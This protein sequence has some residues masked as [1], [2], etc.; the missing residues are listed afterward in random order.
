M[1]WLFLLLALAGCVTPPATQ[2]VKVGVY[3][4]CVKDNPVRP[5][6]FTS[7]LAADASDGE[8]VIALARDKPRHLKYEGQL[9]AV[10]AG[11]L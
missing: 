4:S 7:A 1:K 5:V 8:K 9:E 6:Y 10:I 11:C 3:V 2:E